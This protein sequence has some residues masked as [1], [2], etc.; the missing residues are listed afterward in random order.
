MNK[1]V[2]ISTKIRRS[3]NLVWLISASWIN[4][5]YKNRDCLST[6]W[7]LEVNLSWIIYLFIFVSMVTLTKVRTF[8]LLAFSW[9]IFDPYW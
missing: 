7:Y 8:K 4:L 3:K 9:T 5:F 2:N 6:Y 1:L